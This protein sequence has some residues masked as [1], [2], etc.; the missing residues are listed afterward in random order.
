MLAR[1][2]E[3]NNFLQL[4]YELENRDHVQRRTNLW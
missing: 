4:K 2:A 1:H 3:L